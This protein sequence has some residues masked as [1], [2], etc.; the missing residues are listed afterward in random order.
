MGAEQSTAGADFNTFYEGLPDDVCDQIEALCEKGEDRLLK[1]HSG[2]PPPFPMVPIGI[3]VRLSTP[4]ASAALA[5]VPR[6]QRKHYEMI[7][8]AM[9]EL[10]FWISFFSHLTAIVEGNC[11]EKLQELALTAAWKGSSAGKGPDSFSATWSKLEKGKQEAI[12]ALVA[13]EVCGPRLAIRLPPASIL[14]PCISSTPH[15]Q[16]SVLN[17]RNGRAKHCLRLLPAHRRPFRLCR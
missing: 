10:D 16:L 1:V 17:S 5:T 14:V 4:M 11:P 8:K 13:K 9:T 12:A 6:L 15:A 7:P 3:T 2:A